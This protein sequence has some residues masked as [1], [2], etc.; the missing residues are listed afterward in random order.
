MAGQS[1]GD[2]G[3]GVLTLLILALIVIAITYFAGPYV[4][5]ALVTVRMYLVSGLEMV[6]YLGQLQELRDA[7]FAL[8]STTMREWTGTGLS[9]LSHHL[10]WF[11][12]VP[13][14]SVFALYA[15][16]VW[17]RNPSNLY[18]RVHSMKS[19]LHSEVEVWPWASPILGLDLVKTSILDGPWAMAKTPL[20]FSRHYKLIDEGKV[21]NRK[22]AERVF[23]SQLGSLWES[24]DRMPKYMQ[25]LFACFVAQAC[26]DK[27]GA[28]QGLHLMAVGMAKKNVDYGW[29]EPLLKK[30]SSDARTR[31]IIRTS[32][33]TTTTLCAALS[34]G[35]KNGVLPPNYFIWLRPVNRPLWYALN[36]VG[37]RTPFCEVAGIHAHMLAEGVAGHAIERPYVIKAVDALDIALKEIV[38]D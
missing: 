6:P 17:R 2:S 5:H 30:H 13:F 27:E 26:K 32:A 9:S 24:P 31:K 3:D 25:A 1:G 16:G 10:R 35:R 4:L 29:V 28:R 20:N 23:A 8:R 34:A 18:R 33:Y 21:V 36:G 19:L 12:F 38:F 14:A 7:D 37:R 11:L 15:Y 22:R